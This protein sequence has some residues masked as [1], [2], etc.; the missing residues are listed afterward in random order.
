MAG[1]SPGATGRQWVE[2]GD[3]SIDAMAGCDHAR[4][5]PGDVLGLETPGG[6]GWGSP[7]PG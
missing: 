4:L 1:G 5:E 3:G 2:R 6:G 7:A